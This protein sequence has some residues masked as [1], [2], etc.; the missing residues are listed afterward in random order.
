MHRAK[1]LQI[2]PI[3]C[4]TAFRNR[5]NVIDL[6]TGSVSAVFQA[7]NTIWK[8]NPVCLSAG[9]PSGGIVEAVVLRAIPLRSMFDAAVIAI[10]HEFRAAWRQAG[11]RGSHWHHITS[12]AST[13][14][15]AGLSPS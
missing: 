11:P 3:K 4:G 13:C 6:F 14:G 5:A 2:A 7:F 9:A 1:I 15:I 8:F 12:D 10:S